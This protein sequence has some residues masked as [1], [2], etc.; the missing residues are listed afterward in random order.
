MSTN[1][2]LVVSLKPVQAVFTPFVMARMSEDLFRSSESYRPDERFP[3]IN[4]FLYCA[5]IEIGLKSA[6]L[7]KDCTQKNKARIKKCGHHLD[8]VLSEFEA[9]FNYSLFTN[10]EES[11]I[12]AA[13]VY[14]RDKGL[15]YFT[16]PVLGSMLRAFDDF[17]P[18]DN[19]AV[20]SR[21]VNDYIV[22]EKY[23]IDATTSD[24]TSG[25]LINFY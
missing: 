10:N 3:L 25:G 19:I 17:P 11:T 8:K 15:E 5:S 22:S 23:F 2:H 1:N 14:Y 7:S 16:T 6:I 21:K 12:F 24:E 4:F 18:I 9:D 20:A 13:N